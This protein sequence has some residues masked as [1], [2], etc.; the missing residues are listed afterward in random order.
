MRFTAVLIQALTLAG[1]LA[2]AAA[3]LPK[4]QSVTQVYKFTGSP[5]KAEGIAVRPNGQI[6][7]SFFDKGEA[8]LV[9]P[10][11]KKASKVATFTDA[12]CSAAIAEV[13]TD[14]FAVVAGQYGTSSKAGSWGVWKVDFSAGGATPTTTLVK[15]V[16][17]S[18]MWNGL[19]TFTNGTVLIGDASKGAVF[20]MNVLT[21][22]YS[23]AIQD[24]TMAPSSGMPYDSPFLAIAGEVQKG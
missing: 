9:D 21:G 11:T 19:T 10:A 2:S 15:K 13:A 23:I 7:V 5:V 20:K 8:W 22:D 1:T 17:E 16:P 14:V 6:L 18:G 4:R 24:S 3:L 12:T